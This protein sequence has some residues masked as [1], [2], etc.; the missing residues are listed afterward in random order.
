MELWHAIHAPELSLLRDGPA[1]DRDGRVRLGSG[2]APEW[3]RLAQR[4]R[5]AGDLE[6]YPMEDRGLASN[7]TRQEHRPAPGTE[8]CST[9]QSTVNQREYEIEDLI[10]VGVDDDGSILFRVRWKGV[11]PRTILESPRAVFPGR[12][13]APQGKD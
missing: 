11:T 8:E 3:D 5:F 12:W 1:P 6:T 13:S 10:A 4:G 7:A 9:R 2:C